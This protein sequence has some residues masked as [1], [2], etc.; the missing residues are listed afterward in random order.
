MANTINE[1]NRNQFDNVIS[2]DDV[3]GA[4]TSSLT[5][6]NVSSDN[7]T[8][9][10]K[11]D[12]DTLSEIISK[13][14]STH[15]NKTMEDFN[16]YLKMCQEKAEEEKSSVEDIINE[17][18]EA[19]K[20]IANTISEEEIAKLMSMG[21]DVTSMKFTNLMG[22]LDTIR[23]DEHKE[24]ISRII[25][26][27]HTEKTGGNLEATANCL[28]DKS[29]GIEGS[30]VKL[31]GIEGEIKLDD[32]EVAYLLDNEM[33]ITKENLYKAHFSSAKLSATNNKPKLSDEVFEKLRNQIEKIIESTGNPIDVDAIEGAEF[34]LDNDLPITG[35]NISKYLTIKNIN[36]NYIP[37]N[38]EELLALAADDLYETIKGIDT[39]AII[40][41]SDNVI[42]LKTKS[43]TIAS[44]VYELKNNKLIDSD[45]NLISLKRQLEEIRLMMTKEAS[46]RLV[47]SDLFINTRELSKVVEELKSLEKSKIMDAFNKEGVI[48][49]D[50]NVELFKRT[51]EEL[52]SLGNKS[53]EVLGAPLTGTDFSIE[54]LNNV[55]YEKA[56]KAYET[57]Q[58]TVR[59]DLGDSINKAFKNTDFEELLNRIDGYDSEKSE[60]AAKILSLN[61]LPLNEDNINKVKYYDD[62]V[63]VLIKSFYPEAVLG[64]I[65]DGINPL[66]MDIS[67]L[68]KVI[69]EKNYNQGVSETEDFAKFLVDMEKQGIVDEEERK[70]YIGIYRLLNQVTESNNKEIGWIAGNNSEFTMKNLLAATRSQKSVNKNYVADEKTGMLDIDIDNTN[71]IDEQINSAFKIINQLKETS[72]YT[73]EVKE[74]MANNMISPS[75]INIEAVNLMLNNSQGIYDLLRQMRKKLATNVEADSTIE[76]SV[77]EET[78]NMFKSLMGEEIEPDLLQSG[79]DEMI[80]SLNKTRDFFRE[81][82]YESAIKGSLSAMDLTALKTLHSGI[83]ILS[84]MAQNDRYQIPVQIKNTVQVVNLS[85]VKTKE[86]NNA[87]IE[88]N[89][90]VSEYGNIKSSIVATKNNGK[91]ILDGYIESDTSEGNKELSQKEEAII[92]SLKNKEIEAENL[93]FGKT[94]FQKYSG[95]LDTSEL[96]KVAMGFIKSLGE[97]L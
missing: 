82:M 35:E 93:Y 60:R 15:I 47:K 84:N 78:K 64:L 86:Q 40:P 1:Y 70:S 81:A 12:E 45:N 42:D 92:T 44:V 6:L 29:L 10:D 38:D 31:L 87:K 88:I 65:K 94:N 91:F 9:E 59:R 69:K 52:N 50:D 14:K 54:A 2:K 19:A 89:M 56:N 96:Y 21:I 43:Y 39:N 63:N 37:E 33:H 74:F 48:Y 73:M 18:K 4:A 34:L 16:D 77:D 97:E 8:D 3:L 66:Q 5:K 61:N 23:A 41:N 76:N 58:T 13:G 85:I 25:E 49:N 72:E 57:L 11:S 36:A 20:K 55:S 68:N 53:I 83:N 67:E 28:K 22:M 71:K 80:E 79:R 26:K 75:I 24:K 7:K 90:K 30:I 62:Q 17:E 32:K 51:S 95:N 27:N 46:M